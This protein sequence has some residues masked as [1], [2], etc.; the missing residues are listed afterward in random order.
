MSLRVDAHRIG[1]QVSYSLK[2][3]Y[4]L[5]IVFFILKYLRSHLYDSRKTFHT[6]FL[7][8]KLYV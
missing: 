6:L 4:I 7:Q 1:F 8:S 5:L 3:T 2:Y